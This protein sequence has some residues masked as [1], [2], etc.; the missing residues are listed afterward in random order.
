MHAS[1]SDRW[2]LLDTMRA[3]GVIGV[4]HPAAKKPWTSRNLRPL[5]GLD[6]HKVRPQVWISEDPWS[7]HDP[8][9]EADDCDLGRASGPWAGH[10]WFVCDLLRY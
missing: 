1:V 7:P 5:I 2:V 6:G 10:R 4:V 8:V 9:V 3:G